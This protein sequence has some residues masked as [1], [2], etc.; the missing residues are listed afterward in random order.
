[1]NTDCDLCHTS[2]DGKN[3][4][5]GSSDGFTNQTVE[6]PGLGC[7]GC[8]VGSAL[9]E[10]HIINNVP[11]NCYDCHDPETPPAENVN[12]PYYGTALTLAN[13]PCNDVQAANTNENW[14]IGDFLGLDN[15]GDNLYDQADF[16]CG[17][18][19]QLV[20]AVREGNDIRI[21]WETV[22]GRTDV[23]QASTDV[24]GGYTDLSAPIAISGVGPVVTNFVDIGEA[25]G[26]ARFYRVRSQP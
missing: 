8:H 21:S 12:P 9:R 23:L 24:A 3:P 13:N 5:I 16:D 17:P 11:D 18:P 1:M 10:H 26:A 2:G 7:S 19:Y 25:A 14:T 20:S 15:D 22:G 4:Y 6:I